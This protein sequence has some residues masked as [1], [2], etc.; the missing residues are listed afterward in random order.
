MNDI[1]PGINTNHIMSKKKAIGIVILLVLF[2]GLVVFIFYPDDE[3]TC[4]GFDCSSSPNS[5]NANPA[6]VTCQ[7]DPCLATEC[8]TVAPTV[9]VEP[10]TCV[11]FDCSS[12]PNSLN[13][14][15]AGVTCQADPCLAT[16]CCTVA[17]T[18]EVEPGSGGSINNCD[19]N[20][21]I[22]TNSNMN[23]ITA[24]SCDGTALNA[25]CSHT[26]NNGYT[27]GSVTCQADGTWAVVA[28]DQLAPEPAPSCIRPTD[29]A[30]NFSSAQETLTING[31]GV[32][33]IT[34]NAGY[35]PGG[36]N[37]SAS[38]CDSADTVYNL[39][40][41]TEMTCSGDGLNAL[42]DCGSGATS[43]SDG[44]VGDGYTC[45]CG[46]GYTGADVSN[47]PAI[48]EQNID[49]VGSFGDCDYDCFKTYTITTQKSG[50]GR[51]CTYNAGA[52]YACTA[53]ECGEYDGGGDY[54][55][56]T[57]PSMSDQEYFDCCMALAPTAGC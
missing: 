1:K 7:A 31:F 46:T 28:C 2:I 30:Y 52:R 56:C 43:C 16:E 51:S 33:G 35:G 21:P 53:S 23:A 38:V 8:C 49:C 20:E 57:D 14:N 22:L 6:G 15:P 18:A 17:P 47:G 25:E 36:D 41:C 5:L 27:D 45:S 4:V 26:C 42:V 54:E 19:A 13:A 24:D 40:G 39:T 32:T 50:N 48:C 10:G 37:I 29:T 3:N 55:G 44:G 9:E 12:S 11:G 34:C